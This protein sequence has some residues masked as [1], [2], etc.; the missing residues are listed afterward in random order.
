M[1]KIHFDES[2]IKFYASVQDGLRNLNEDASD[3][4]IENIIKII[5]SDYLANK[6]EMI[7]ICELFALYARYSTLKMKKNL[8]KLYEKIMDNIKSVLPDE[9]PFFWKIFGGHLYFKFWLYQK[10]L[11]SLD[12]AILCAQNQKSSNIIETFLPEIIENR[13]ELFDKELKYIYNLPYEEKD[14]DEIKNQRKIH[15]EWLQNSCDYND[16][17]YEQIETNRLRLSIK[18]DDVDSF[19]RILSESNLSINSNISELTFETQFISPSEHSL[20]DYSIFCNSENIFKFLI[21]NE[22]EI[23]EFTCYHAVSSNNYEIIHIIESKLKEKFN[24]NAIKAAINLWNNEIYDYVLDNSNDDYKFLFDESPIEPNKYE[25]FLEIFSSVISSSNYVLFESTFLPIL[26]RN[27][28]FVEE[29]IYN[30]IFICLNQMSCFFFDYFLQYDKVDINYHSSDNNYT[31]LSKAIEN[32]NTNGIHK[33]LSHENI[34]INEPAFSYYPSL[35]VACKKCIDLKSIDLIC[36]YPSFDISTTDDHYHVSAFELAMSMGN[37][38]I[39]EYMLNKFPE[40]IHPHSLTTLFFY[41]LNNNHLYTLKVALKFF[42]K[43][44][45]KFTYQKIVKDIIKS[46]K[47]DDD[48]KS[49]YIDTIK[50][51]ITEL[52]YDCSKFEEEEEEEEFTDLDEL[53]ELIAKHLKQQEQ[54]DDGN[55]NKED[56]GDNTN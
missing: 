24:K 29:K 12:Y 45:E 33:V 47:N 39:T 19:Q 53:I 48:Y 55:N 43:K 54:N 28:T 15:L 25:N 35:F 56:D 4:E 50:S 18:R 13:R 51:I 22:A 52:G 34:R 31:I 27:Q 11:I 23:N 46:F 32:E 17:K 30:I 44:D 10:G 26:K 41:A 20:L 7:R 8:F 3:E 40:Q 36:N 38:Y 14:V 6:D 16:S 42:M 21:M 49:Q 1:D 37:F 5:P 2:K 9:S